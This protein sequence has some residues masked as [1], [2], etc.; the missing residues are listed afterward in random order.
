MHSH[1][2]DL[3]LPAMPTQLP[4]V[5]AVANTMAMRANF[6]LDAIADI[7]MAI[8]ELCSQLMTKAGAGATLR[9]SFLL[10]PESLLVRGSIPAAV[11][12]ALN[13][14]SFG[15]RVLSTL[16]DSASTWWEDELHIEVVKTRL[17]VPE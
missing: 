4:V 12:V 17:V 7:T 8:D 2:V 6:D 15:W 5:R 14:A 13:T 16:V 3:R 9:C 1:P 10:R 11:D